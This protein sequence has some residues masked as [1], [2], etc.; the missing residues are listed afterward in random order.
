MSTLGQD[1]WQWASF[2]GRRIKHWPIQ[3]Q[4]IKVRHTYF[5]CPSLPLYRNTKVDVT[6]FTE[7]AYGLSMYLSPITKQPLTPCPLLQS[8]LDSPSWAISFSTSV[9]FSL[10]SPTLL[11]HQPPPMK[12]FHANTYLTFKSSGSQVSKVK[13]LTFEKWTPRLLHREKDSII[14]I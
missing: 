11:A 13:D 7:L 3:G 9:Y 4:W 10:H 14:L 12:C 6:E 2:A 1:A 5:K 8:F